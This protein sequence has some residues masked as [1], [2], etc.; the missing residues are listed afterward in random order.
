MEFGFDGNPSPLL[1][2][3]SIVTQSIFSMLIGLVASHWVFNETIADQKESRKK[4]V[5][6]QYRNDMNDFVATLRHVNSATTHLTTEPSVDEI[7]IGAYIIGEIRNALQTKL[8]RHADAVLEMGES[9]KLFLRQ[10]EIDQTTIASQLA[11]TI[12]QL[13]AQLRFDPS[14]IDP[15]AQKSASQAIE[16]EPYASLPP[17]ATDTQEQ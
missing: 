1:R 17:E 5:A 4:A 14:L 16:A 7:R 9:P 13:P 6:R 3:G 15:F 12:S 10:M 11:N 8:T 2:W